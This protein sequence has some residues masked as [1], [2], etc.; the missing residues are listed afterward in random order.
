MSRLGRYFAGGY[1]PRGYPILL[2][3]QVGGVSVVGTS[4]RVSTIDFSGISGIQD[5]D[6]LVA[7]F[8][9]NTPQAMTLA[10]ESGRWTQAANIIQTATV[11]A[12]MCVAYGFLESS[13]RTIACS[14]TS[15][16]AIGLTQVWRGV[17]ASTPLDVAVAT[18]SGIDAHRPDPP[19]V[20]PTTSYSKVIAI[21]AGKK[22]VS[23]SITLSA[24]SLGD[25]IKDQSGTSAGLMGSVDWTSGAY[26]PS[27]FTST[28]SDGAGDAWVAATMVLRAN[29]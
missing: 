26:N 8:I 2:G 15:A 4:P 14:T 28:Q 10:T 22:N 18:A 27:G 29:E 25:V 19:S 6:F 7:A 5:G 3:S 20:T 11:S 23:L 17:D 13:D 16:G 24:G 21:G 12:S 9:Y 1:A